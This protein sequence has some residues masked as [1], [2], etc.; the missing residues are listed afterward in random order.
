VRTVIILLLALS[1]GA[2]A[3]GGE[4]PALRQQAERLAADLARE[5]AQL[6][7]PA[8]PG[9]QAAFERCRRGLF[10][11]SL[12][13]RSFVPYALWGRRARDGATPLKE[14]TLTQFAPDVLAGMYLPL[15][16]FN[17]SYT[18]DYEAREGMFLVRLETAFR[19]RLAPGQFPY[20]FWHDEAKWSTYQGANTLLLWIDPKLVRIKVAQFTDRGTTPPIVASRPVQQAKFD[21]RWM[22]T[23]ADGREQPQVTLF[24]GLFSADNPFLPKLD[25]AYKTLALRMRDGQCD[26]CHVPD[27]PHGM[28]RIVLLQTPAHAAGEIQ[29]L[30]KAVREDKMP[31]DETDIEQPLDDKLKSALLESGAAFETLVQS[32]KDWEA[33]RRPLSARPREAGE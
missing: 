18:V 26:S 8:Q 30:M 2:H 14:T 5:L 22:W 4:P 3:A 29:R 21:G 13:K 9:D 15:F 16:M 23:D 32:A 25:T 6:C 24:D 10:R 20:P 7:P 33:G 19:N 12:L 1:A 27:N 28:K 17:G 11:D 31:R